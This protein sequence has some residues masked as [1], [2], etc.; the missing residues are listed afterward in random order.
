MF[1]IG[2][3]EMVILV[4]AA[5]VILG[6]ERL[7]GAVR[8]TAQSLRQ[9]RDYASGATSQLRSEL[10]P[11]LD[12][13]R[14]PLE[15][16]NELRRPLNELRGM[17]PRS[18]VTKHL[19]DGDDSLFTGKFDKPSSI[20]DAANYPQPN[21]YSPPPPPKPLARNEKPPIDFDAT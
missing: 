9:I 16:L 21:D 20:S 15:E 5:L 13:L 14:K 4:F 8:W 17:T 12:E 19:L 1:N 10:G 2:W 11:E 6:P 18:M 7:P 3:P